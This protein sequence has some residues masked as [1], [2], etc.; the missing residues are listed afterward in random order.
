MLC[1]ILTVIQFFRKPSSKNASKEY[2]KAVGHLAYIHKRLNKICKKGTLERTWEPFKKTIDAILEEHKGKYKRPR[3]LMVLS[4][5]KNANCIKLMGPQIVSK[6]KELN[7]NSISDVQ[8][9]FKNLIKKAFTP[10]ILRR[11][12]GECE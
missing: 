11:F 12:V 2:R 3:G 4:K 6:Y 8:Q 9:A 5:K 1:L 10:A 7:G